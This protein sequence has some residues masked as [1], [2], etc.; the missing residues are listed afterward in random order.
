MKLIL[1]RKRCLLMLGVGGNCPV[2]MIIPKNTPSFPLPG[3]HRQTATQYQSKNDCGTG[4]LPK[5]D[6]YFLLGPQEVVCLPAAFA[7]DEQP[8]IEVERMRSLFLQHNQGVAA[9][10]WPESNIGRV[11]PPGDSIV[12]H[13]GSCAGKSNKNRLCWG[14]F[15]VFSTRWLAAP[16]E[17][18]HR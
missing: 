16:G 4:P 9:I 10:E 8:G 13:I 18:R 6:S 11:C 5:P 7:P 12:A 15:P 3:W 17:A 2:E 14:R 1:G